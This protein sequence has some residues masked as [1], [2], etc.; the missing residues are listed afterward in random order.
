[1]S[2]SDL[3]T[4]D[5]RLRLADSR[6]KINIGRNFANH[7]LPTVSR[8]PSSSVQKSLKSNVVKL[9]KS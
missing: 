9:S 3:Q 2:L 1:M 5:G 7:H 6:V 8:Y 4:L